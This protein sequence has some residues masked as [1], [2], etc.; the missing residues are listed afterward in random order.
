MTEESLFHDALAKPA[1]ERAAFL[2][3]ACAKEPQL[4]AAV[5]A[6]LAAHES[7]GELL[8]RPP[9]EFRSTAGPEPLRPA[10]TT[11]YQPHCEPGTVVGGRYTLV[12]RIGEGGMGEVWVAKQTEPVK[13]K[14]ALKLIKAGMDSKAVLQRFNQER[15]ALALMEHPNI[16]KVLDGGV[17]ADH[18]PFFVMELVNGLPLTGFCDQMKLPV[19]ERLELFTPIC[20]A[21]Q[22]AHQKGIVH[23]DLKPSN[24]L[25]T[26]I[27]G[28]P[29]P[30]VIDFGVAKATS[31][32]LTDETMSTGFGAVVGTLEYM[33][34]EQTGFSGDDIDTRA[35]I[36]SLGVILYEL[37]TGLRP[38]D[39]KRLKKAAFTEMIRIIQEEEPS[40]PSTRL[41]SDESL[42]SLAAMRQTEPNKL[43]ALLRGELD[44]VVMKCL[45]KQR[46]RRYETA[47]ALS[48]DIQ[49]YLADEV[50]EARPPSASYRLQKFVKRHRGQVIASS[51]VLLALVAGI[52]VSAYFALLAGDEAQMARTAEKN[53]ENEAKAARKAEADA[54]TAEM[55]AENEAK[56]ARK[57]EDEAKWQARLANDARHAIQI[58]LA[59]RAR[60]EKDYDRIETLLA[61][62]RPE[63]QSAWETG[64]VRTLWLRETPLRAALK[65]HVQGITDIAFSPDG[66]RVL[67]GSFDNTPRVWDAETGHEKALLKGHAQGITSVAFSPDG[68][69]VLTG[70]W[71]STARVWDAETGQEKA[72]FKGHTG[73]VN[74]VAFSPDGKRVLTGSSDTTARIWDAETG[75][76]KALLKGHTAFVRDVAYS[77]DGKRVLTGC[78]DRLARVWDAETGQ[79]K[80]LLKGHTGVVMSVAFSPDGMRVLAGSWD[81]TARVWDAETGKEKAQ[82]QGHTGHVNSVAFSPDGNHVLT[83]SSDST[84]RVWDAETGQVK[85]LL[86]GHALGITSV[87]FSPDGKYVLTGG[88]DRTARVWDAE[89]GQEKATLKGHTGQVNRVAFSPDGKRIGTGSQDTTARVWHAEMGQEVDAFKREDALGFT[90]VAFSPDC[91]RVLTGSRGSSARV[92][93]AETGQEKALIKGQNQENQEITSV[94]FSPDGKRVLIGIA[95]V[96]IDFGQGPKFLDGES[97]IWD[98]ETGQVKALLK[99]H[100]LGITSVAFSPDGMRVLTGNWDNTARVWDAETGQEKATLKGHTAQVNRVAFSPDGKRVLTGG[101]DSTVRVW[102][103]ETGQ[104]KALMTGHTGEIWS[105]AF[106]P[107]GKFIL[108]GG[109]DRTARVWDAETGQEKLSLMGH[110][111]RITSVAFSPDGKR[112]LT[113][114]LDTTARVWDVETGQEKLSLMGHALGI[115]SVAFSPDGKRALTGSQDGTWRAWDASMG[116]GDVPPGR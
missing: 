89:T 67:T 108:T 25:V 35:D 58:E 86:S 60:E 23:R 20:Q 6:L 72:Q 32:K 111:L 10:V 59:L 100:A 68:M 8:G 97:K 34:P 19:H 13:R 75:Q 43:M 87:A 27:D 116:P 83:G 65:G 21:V 50:V 5:E 29:V 54:K 51:L 26:I 94:A 85:A 88:Q 104:Q 115:T 101:G 64:F 42:P 4:R 7:S 48:R 109:G 99:G 44:W 62:M 14:V 2:D 63:Y 36:Y 106:S 40:K 17:T 45:E 57:A 103:A 66:K 61:T 22:H 82:L 70:S 3:A 39:A 110:A 105:V 41:S 55:K 73:H 92:W 74:S 112:A 56:A 84:A 11:D 77:P 12:E 78:D 30:K 47:S 96:T 37:L 46:E 95:D 16:A 114:S 102:D 49:R 98:A 81:S 107:D 80:A 38:I 28:K 33:S 24:I 113:A 31:G 90:D 93:D 1:G 76:Q 15:Q 52:V 91:K 18:R 9:A 79:E 71:D 53:A 69:R